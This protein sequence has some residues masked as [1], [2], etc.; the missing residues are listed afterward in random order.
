MDEVVRV[1]FGLHRVLTNPDED[2]KA[3]RLLVEGGL[4]IFIKIYFIDEGG[5][6]LLMNVVVA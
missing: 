4:K 1:R 3:T 6:L 2:V 5:Q